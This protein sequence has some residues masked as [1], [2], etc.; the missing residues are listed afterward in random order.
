MRVRVPPRL[1][2]VAKFLTELLLI[3]QFY[4]PSERGAARSNSQNS[5]KLHVLNTSWVVFGGLRSL[6]YWHEIRETHC[7]WTKNVFIDANRGRR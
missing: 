2:G 3:A 1:L 6:E 7:C 5:A 4:D